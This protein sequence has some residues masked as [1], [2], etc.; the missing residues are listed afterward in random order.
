MKLEV[1]SS[2]SRL[3]ES[4]I[5]TR[6]S[7]AIDNGTGGLKVKH[8]PSGHWARS[9]SYVLYHCQAWESRREV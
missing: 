9:R 7:C 2:L 8:A 5:R 6:N 1:I 3:Y 4:R